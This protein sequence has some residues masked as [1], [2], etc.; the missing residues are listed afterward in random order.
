MKRRGLWAVLVL[1]L[2]GWATLRALD[3]DGGG[4]S[5]V[6]ETHWMAGTLNATDDPDGDGFTNLE[7][8]YYHTNPLD[9]TSRPALRIDIPTADD[10]QVSFFA[11]MG[12]RFEMEQTDDLLADNWTYLHSI[13]GTNSTMAHTEEPSL[14]KH[15]FRLIPMGAE[16]NDGDGLDVFEESLLGTSDNAID[17]DGDGFSDAFEF[18]H[19]EAGFDPQHAPEDP[20]AVQ[21]ADP[22]HDGL[23]NLQEQERG[24]EPDNPHT[25]GD[26][27]PDGEDGWAL[28]PNFTHPPAT[29][30][31]ALIDLS[32]HLHPPE[33]GVWSGEVQ[34]DDTGGVL[35]YYVKDIEDD[36]DDWYNDT[37]E[38]TT[39]YVNG[40]TVT[41]PTSFNGQVEY[42]WDESGAWCDLFPDPF[43]RRDGLI[44]KQSFDCL[45][46]DDH[47]N[48]LYHAYALNETAYDTRTQ[49][50]VTYIDQLEGKI[51][52]I[53]NSPSIVVGETALQFSLICAEY[54]ASRCAN[55]SLHYDGDLPPGVFQEEHYDAFIV[56]DDCQISGPDDG[57][58]LIVGVGA[59]G[60][61]LTA[62]WLWWPSEH[63]WRHQGQ[64]TSLGEGEFSVHTA[65]DQDIVVQEF[66]EQVYP[67]KG[68]SSCSLDNGAS[69]H[70][71]MIWNA[72]SNSLENV[73]FGKTSDS[74]VM[75]SEEQGRV[76][77]N[78]QIL[79]AT[80]LLGNASTGWS[81]FKL[82]D[83][84]SHGMIVGTATLNATE[85]VVAL[86]PFELIVSPVEA[87]E[88]MERWSNT[89][90]RRTK[91][92]FHS[93]PTS[94]PGKWTRTMIRS[95]PGKS[96]TAP[97]VH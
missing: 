56:D 50:N 7:E 34:V 27:V 62:E 18:R 26:E 74:L 44:I 24:T 43:L 64:V 25:D 21:L 85:T 53:G 37:A 75:L 77:I 19:R 28:D 8:Y 15:F 93:L 41:Y 35:Q 95:S 40:N 12:Q 3:I 55:Y 83:I 59:Y 2:G 97:E 5:D 47:P 81:N 71:F 22:D 49:T 9:P 14:E 88:T 4:V 16:N 23:T 46:G 42:S 91:R 20:I 32:S 90:Y 80:Q 66:A 78:G 45:T 63:H 87:A 13:S 73:K 76:L 33:D 70:D 68:H 89:M 10:V 36:P 30:T 94:W 54:I 48:Y 6:W 11:P 38:L 72:T 82:S 57:R 31:Y 84:N 79:H 52:N 67:Y 65:L 69:F 60:G 1:A 92:R 51:A 58:Q 29:E 39:L 17:T 96:P 61:V 86:L